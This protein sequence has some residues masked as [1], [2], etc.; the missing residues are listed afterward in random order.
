M[1]ELYFAGKFGNML[2]IWKNYDEFKKDLDSGAWP[3]NKPVALRT[4]TKPGL[5]PPKYCVRTETWEVEGLLEEWVKLGIE[6]SAI[7]INELGRDDQIA[8]QGEVMRSPTGLSLRYSHEK[9]VMRTALATKQFHAEGLKAKLILEHYLDAV[10]LDNLNYLL[11]TY[12]HPTV[13]TVIE[14]S[15]YSCQVGNLGWNT[16]FWEVRAY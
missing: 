9:T 4:A 5:V 2:V 14:F 1:Y 12:Q 13:T 11:D 3:A 6:R 8:L 16:V 15:T 10:S 7:N